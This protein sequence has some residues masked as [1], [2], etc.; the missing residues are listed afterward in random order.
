MNADESWRDEVMNQD[1]TY[2][3]ELNQVTEQIIGSAFTVSNELGS[4]FLE[5][6][7]ENALAHELRKA[8]ARVR[9]QYPIQVHYD[10]IVV[11][12]Y[13]ADLLVND[14]VLVELKAMQALGNVEMAQCL[15]YLKATGLR[16]C[17]LLNFG[18]PRVEV[19]RIVHDF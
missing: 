8:G 18:R 12:D 1:G 17:L 11:G 19:K 10:G 13:V 15:N 2:R 16:I 3:E 14:C 6:V 9:Q 7:Y 4:G 5:K